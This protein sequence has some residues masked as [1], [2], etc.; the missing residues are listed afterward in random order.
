MMVATSNTSVLSIITDTA[1]FPFLLF[2]PASPAFFLN[3]RLAAC[4]TS[5]YTPNALTL[6]ASQVL[7]GTLLTLY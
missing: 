7:T 4:V 1:S 3:L 2:S 5:L 6:N